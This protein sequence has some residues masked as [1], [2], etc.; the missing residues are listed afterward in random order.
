MHK[1]IIVYTS[2]YKVYEKTTQYK[3]HQLLPVLQA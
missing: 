2:N 1:N 3:V